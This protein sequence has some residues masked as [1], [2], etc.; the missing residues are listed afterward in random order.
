MAKAKP[1]IVVQPARG[2]GKKITPVVQPARNK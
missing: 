1:A 2:Q